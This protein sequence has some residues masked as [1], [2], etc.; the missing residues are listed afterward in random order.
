MQ[1]VL[2]DEHVQAD[3]KLAPVITYARAL[4]I[5]RHSRKKPCYRLPIVGEEDKQKQPYICETLTDSV[6]ST[7]GRI[8]PEQ[9][10]YSVA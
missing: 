3:V 5:Y 1:N 2:A 6:G 4:W 9:T 8:C 10:S 7:Q